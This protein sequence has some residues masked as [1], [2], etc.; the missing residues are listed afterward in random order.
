VNLSVSRFWIVAGAFLVLPSSPSATVALAAIVAAAVVETSWNGR[1]IG[2]DAGVPAI[3]LPDR[4]GGCRALPPDR[5]QHRA[6]PR[7]VGD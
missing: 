3:V 2:A 6:V 5:A 4:S 7:L 1:L